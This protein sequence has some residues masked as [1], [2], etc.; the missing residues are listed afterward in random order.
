MRVKKS[1][2]KNTINY[3]II[4]DI[5]VGNKRTSTIV[6]N[7]G[8]HETLQ[9][10]HPEME[11]MEWAKLRA[12]ELTELD[13]E[14]KQEILVKLHENKQLK[15]NQRNEYHGGYLFLQNIYYQ[16]GLD[17][18]CQDIQK[19]YHFSFHLDTIL[20]R[21]LYGRI[22]FPSSKRSTAHFSQTLLEP[23]T[24][25]LQ[26]LYRGLEIIAKETD[27]IQ[28]QLYKNSTALSSRKT[29]VLYYDCTNFYFEIEEED[30]E[31]Q[32]RQYGYS[33]E[34]RPNPIV[35]M[36]LF[37]DSQGI[38][39]AF[40]ITPGNTNEQTTMKPLEKKIIKDFEKA[41][42]VV[43][44]DAGLSSIGNKRYNNI[45]GRAFV[46]TQ[47]VKKLK[48]EDK[49]WATSST[50]WRL[51]GDR[52]ETF[53]DISALDESNQDFLYRQVFYKECPLPQ[54]GLED[55][56]LIVTFS[57]KYRDY[58]RNIRER[59]IQRASKWIGKPADYKKK[60]STDPKRFLKVTE[61]TS[62]GE[63]AEKTFIELDEERVLSEARFDGIYAV[64]TNLDDSIETIVSINQRRWE[65]EECFRIMKHEL[66][67]RPLYLSR[68]DRISAHFTTCFLALI[69]YRYLEL[70]VQKQFTCTELIETLRSY[71]F[72]YLPGFG[73]LPNYTRTAI[74][75]E[76]HQTF[77]FRSDYQIISE[78]K[79]KK[80]LQSS[81]SRKSTHF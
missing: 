72:R 74:T 31:G 36:G 49:D 55:Q 24:L 27:F 3:A 15:Q 63:I 25:E 18:I 9:L 44:T 48:K 51:M 28:E 4:K 30:E 46:T 52:S 37:M 35:Q 19:R 81:K 20:S 6:E 57:A 76:L 71:T 50:G 11:P 17:K 5:K 54:D 77:G 75:D 59:Q 68:E 67:A 41:Q 65:I 78:K 60:Q 16:L 42:F 61:T 7:L 39:L 2:S 69:I 56:R 62:D 22:L 34:H 10:L 79:M 40:S 14:D 70:A 1:V 73:Y 29:D 47:S 13:K 53:Y 66:K 80:I 23:K 64:T 45:S 8:N 33:K 58:Q 43:C 32:L 38:P 26:H 12:K 21:L